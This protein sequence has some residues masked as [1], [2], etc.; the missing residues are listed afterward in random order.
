MVINEDSSHAIDKV[1]AFIALGLLG[2]ANMNTTPWSASFLGPL[3]WISI[4]GFMNM[5]RKFILLEVYLVWGIRY[6][7]FKMKDIINL[8]GGIS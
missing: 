8:V 7:N 5:A 1:R 3:K 4:L 6:N 2:H